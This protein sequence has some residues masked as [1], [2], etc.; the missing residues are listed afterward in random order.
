MTETEPLPAPRFDRHVER[1]GY[2]W[3]YFDALSDDGRHG[4]TVIAFVGSVF[5]P[6]YAAARR[7]G[8]GDP[9]HHCALNVALYGRGPHRWALT[10]RGRGALHRSAERFQ[11]GPSSITWNGR[12]IE[13]RVREITVPI[14][15]R[16]RGTIRIHPPALGQTSFRLD[17]AGRHYWW[18]VAPDCRVELLMDQPGLSWEGRGYFDSNRGSEPLEAGFSDWDWSRAPLPEGGCAVLYDKRLRDGSS[19]AMALRFDRHA[20]A[21]PLELPPVAR[22][23]TTAIWRIPRGTRS[24]AGAPARVVETLED[25][26]FY[27][28]SLVEASIAGT[29]VRAFHESLLLDRFASRWVQMLLPFRMPRSTRPFA[30]D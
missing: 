9:E 15:R 16:L 24:E 6:Y 26:P 1:N 11:V 28:R 29:R 27:A 3:W 14:P 4:F 22:L 13:I 5:S 25:T 7:A 10:E 2:L 30:A 21:S 17:R 23:D 12:W 18:P 19:R 8:R 20:E